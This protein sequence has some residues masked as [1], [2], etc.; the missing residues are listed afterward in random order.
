MTDGERGGNRRYNRRVAGLDLEAYLRRTG[1]AC[2]AGPTLDALGALHEAHVG[3]IPFENLDV[4]LGREIRLDVGSLQAKL[5]AARRGGYCFEHNTLFAAVLEALGFAV[6]PLGARVGSRPGDVRRRTHMTLRVDLPEGPHLADVGFGGD[7]P[8]HPVPLDPAAAADGEHR[9]VAEGDG[10]A[11]HGREGSLYTFTLERQYPVDYEVANHFTSTHPSS[12]FRS[13]LD[14]AADVARRRGHPARPRAGRAARRRVR[15]DG[16]PRSRTPAARAGAHVR[17]GLPRRHAVP[18][19]GVLKSPLRST[20]A[21]EAGRCPRAAMDATGGARASRLT[22]L[23]MKPPKLPPRF[24]LPVLPAVAVALWA[25]PAFGQPR[26]YVEARLYVTAPSPSQLLADR[27]FSAFEP[28]EQPD[29]NY[30]TV[31]IDPDRTFQS[32]EGFGGAFTD[33]AA[34]VFAALPPAS[35]EQFL[36]A[37]FDPVDGNGYNL[38]RTT[39]H[40]CDYAAGM[41]TYDE[42]PGDKELAHFSIDHD[43][44]NRLPFIK[45]AQAAAGGLLRLYASPWSPPAWMKTNDDMKHGGKLK[46]EYRQTWADYFVKYVKAYAAEGVPMWGLTVQNEAL[47]TQVWESCLFTA[48]EEREFVRDYLG[49]TL[50][51]QG[52]ASVKLMIWDHNRGLV[53]QRA[54]AAYSDPQASQYIWGTAF[55]WYVGDHHDNVRVL[56]D[57]FPEKGLLFTEGSVRGTW[58]A[59]F[60]LARNVILDLN[61]WTAGWTVWNLLLDERRTASRRRPDGRHDRQCRQQDRASSRSTR[62]TTPSGISPASSSAAPAGSPARPAATTSWPPPSSTPTGRSRSC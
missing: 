18:G 35:Q 58:E 23:A 29:E 4:L 1:A 20:R 41:Y 55:H 52:L 24:L 34:D 12:H 37:A 42:V 9:V 17:A 49:P 31:M 56:H 48:N 28:L 54:Q 47:A 19:S 25:L 16:G 13:T 2:P 38:C 14:R 53:Y 59:A 5:V 62:P 36:R 26:S 11:L 60:R 61:N 3:A 44:Q 40:S 45:R 33:A 30:P 46:P 7:G 8:V 27:G 50:R 22:S 6:T 51:R 10:F 43:R 15:D 57:A 21:F 39:I 32:I